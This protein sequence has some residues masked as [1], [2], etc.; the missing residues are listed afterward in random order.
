MHGMSKRSEIQ[1]SRCGRKLW[2]DLKAV[3]RWSFDGPLQIRAIS[4]LSQSEACVGSGRAFWADS[5]GGSR[6][7]LTRATT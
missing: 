2:S 6:A 3:G 4:P 7:N 1:A 5:D